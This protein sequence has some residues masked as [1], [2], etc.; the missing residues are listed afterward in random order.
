VHSLGQQSAPDPRRRPWAK[1]LLTPSLALLALT[2]A[3]GCAHG[4]LGGGSTPPDH[5]V[6]LGAPLLP[7]V[8]PVG[9]AVQGSLE[10][11]GVRRS[12]RVYLPSRLTPYHAVPLLLAL[13]GGGGSGAQ[14][15]RDSGFDGLAEAD[16]FIVVYPDG[17]PTR[18]GAGGRVW[19]AGGCCGVADQAHED[20]DDV[21][22]VRALI[23]KL[24][25]SYPIDRRKV[26]ATG[27][28]NGAMLSLRLACE[29]SDE[30][31]AVAVQSG[32]LFV[33][34]CRP[35][36]P[37]SVLEIHGTADENV[38]IDGGRGSRDISGSDYPPP[39]QGLKTL[40]ARNGCPSAAKTSTDPHNHA[41][42]YRFWSPC[43]AG[44][45]VE[46]VTITGAN[47]AWMGHPASLLSRLLV[48]K[49]YLGYDSSAA[50][51]SFLSAHPKQ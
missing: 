51:W 49:P 46:W 37:V 40:A 24:R 26:F 2:L 14:F 8:K 12:Y 5:T 18:S 7:A 48:G 34:G 10:V 33:D 11:G 50:A 9:Q 28:S 35:S 4:A 23:G 20:V 21:A 25:A 17:T 22:F 39:L 15:E 31:A 47:H 44:T 13:H 42:H 32:V 36:Q 1:R 43:R 27:H 41:V 6:A 45:A 19:N 38:P 3:A 30:L 29:L 16:H